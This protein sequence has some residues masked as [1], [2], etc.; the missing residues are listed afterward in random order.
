M[1]V[2]LVTPESRDG[3]NA[4]QIEYW[5]ASAGLTW[6]RCHDALNRQI[7]PL[8]LEAIG[9]LAPKGGEHLFDVG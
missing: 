7:A 5:S 2:P 6:A 4:D 9:R 8:G 1:D 3:P